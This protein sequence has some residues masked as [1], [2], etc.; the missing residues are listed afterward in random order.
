MNEPSRS[1]ERLR[2]AFAAA[3]GQPPHDDPCP[4]PG[5]I[6]D[7]VHATLPPAEARG[8]VR[9]VA[10]CP[11]CSADW[12]LA[13]ADPARA[14]TAAS[15]RRPPA[16][17]WTAAAAAVAALVILGWLGVREPGTGAPAFRDAQ[18]IEIRSLVPEDLALSRDRA[19]LRWTPAGPGAS[20]RIELSL[21]DL[22]P[23]AVEH[24]LTE[25]QYEV[26]PELLERVP[27]GSLLVWRVEARLA[28][29]EIVVSP[30]FVHRLE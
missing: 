18:A 13:M 24:A 30:A 9:H 8:V 14:S 15:V 19:V 25:P 4:E 22:T 3:E 10:V 23:L 6:W 11:S 27:P 12:R 26:S 2:A 28:G 16:L 17:A 20:Y 21:D 5:R 29:G 7:A 1:T